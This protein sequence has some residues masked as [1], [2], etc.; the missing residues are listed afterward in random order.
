MSW[1]PE[2]DIILAFGSSGELLEYGNFEQLRSS[3]GYVQRLVEVTAP[4]GGS[5]GGG[6]GSNRDNP[7]DFGNDKDEFEAHVQL[8]ENEQQP[9]TTAVVDDTENLRQTSDLAVWKY[10]AASLGWLRL[11]TLAFFWATD[12]GFATF[13]CGCSHARVVDE[14]PT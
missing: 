5:V 11:A 13:R 8:V 2:A 9:A 10:Y 12:S 6:G 3:A 1:L 4:A 14:P 7:H